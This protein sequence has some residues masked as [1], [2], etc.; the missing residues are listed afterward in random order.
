MALVLQVIAIPLL[1]FVSPVKAAGNTV[2]EIQMEGGRTIV[3]GGNLH[4]LIR[5]KLISGDPWPGLTAIKVSNLPAGIDFSLP[6]TQWGTYP[7]YSIY[8]IDYNLSYYRFQLTASAT[9]VPGTYTITVTSSTSTGLSSTY[10]L[11]IT[12]LSSSAAAVQKRAFPPATPIPLK[13]DWEDHMLTEGARR[14]NQQQIQAEGTYMGGVFYYDGERV[15]YQIADYTKD[16][17]WNACAKYVQDIYQPQIIAN[18]GNFQWISIFSRGLR[19]NYERTG[20]Q[21]SKTA[22]HMMAQEEDYATIGAATDD[23]NMRE[24]AYAL[25]A[26]LDDSAISGTEYAQMDKMAEAMLGQLDQVFIT[27]SYDWYQPFMVGLLSEALIQYYNERKQ[28]P[29]IPYYLERALDGMWS[30]AW[31]P[32][33]N[34][35]AYRCYQDGC[36]TPTDGSL[37]PPTGEKQK[38]VPVD[39]NMLIAPAYAW[40][41][42]QTGDYRYRNMADE[43]F[44]NGV[45]YKDFFHGKQFTQ[46]YRW[47]FDYVKYREQANALAPTGP[48]TDTVAPTV[49]V[50]APS[51]A[52]SGKYVFRASASDNASIG[53]VQFKIDGINAGIPLTQYPFETPVHTHILSNGT[54][55]LTAA[56]TDTAGNSTQSSPV[57]FTVNNP[58]NASF[59]ACPRTNIPR[60]AYQGCYYEHGYTNNYL[61]DLYY[62]TQGSGLEPPATNLGTLKVTKTDSSLNFNFNGQAPATGVSSTFFGVIWQGDMDLAA[63]KYNFTASKGGNDGIRLYINGERIIEN[64]WPASVVPLSFSKTF[65]V[66]GTHRV[67]V[68]Y[69]HGYNNPNGQV[70]LAWTK[71]A[72]YT[73]PVG[74]TGTL[75]PADTVPPTASLTAPASGSTVS[76]AVA[77]SASASDNVG[78][79]GVQFKLD[80]VSLGAEDTA[81]PYAVS[82]N[83]ASSTNG[84]H[85][86]TAVARD[87][88]GNQATA[89]AVTVTVANATSTATTGTGTGS[90]STGTGTGSAGTTGGSSSG[91]ATTPPPATTS[92]TTTTGTSPRLIRLNGTYY[93]LTNGQKQGITSPGLLF[94]LGFDWHDA[95]EATAGEATL[96]D[97]P[98]LLPGDGSL[99]KGSADKT[100][101]LISNGQRH[102]FT[103]A[104]VFRSLGYSFASVLTV[105][106]PELQTLPLSSQL[107]SDSQA[108]HLPG[109][110]LLHQ[111]TVYWAG[112]QHLHPY[113]SLEVYN[114][115]N[116]DNDFSSVVPANAADLAR[117]TGEPATVRW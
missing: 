30:Q 4:L 94:S 38:N 36:Y 98:L 9:T 86:L 77:V 21:N 105:T 72:S 47:S 108:A 12:V 56:A 114:S 65:P 66:T 73:S 20:E 74:G 111:G 84:S 64:W 32:T 85:T 53:A 51:G 109:S 23:F 82:W 116:R 76:G 70:S 63:G 97:G 40:I 52:V 15:F 102:A 60:N 5:N 69:W 50:I 80:G 18:N 29:R 79:A 112:G 48:V 81:A 19:M 10:P 11:T 41:F 117:G 101:Y 59:D 58:V 106:D 16:P 46:Q 28:D 115:W 27:K 42:L 61:N 95:S 8:G 68:E 78:V 6:T 24:T 93:L 31:D 96:P 13:A 17:K 90:T 49:S 55:T 3:Q 88:A 43:A 54:H 2:F 100:V 91:T 113:P 44:A 7:N 75:P 71:D 35:F 103:A 34:G 89:P 22:V 107:L 99:V 83:T 14:C 104:E 92:P 67:R 62:N 26:L 39:L 25:E 110:Q 87:T 33:R 57:T 37:Y 1:A 45:R